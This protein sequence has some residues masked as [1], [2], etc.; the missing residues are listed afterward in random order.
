MWQAS[1]KDYYMGADQLVQSILYFTLLYHRLYTVSLVFAAFETAYY[2]P[3]SIGGPMAGI[4]GA[5]TLL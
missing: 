5:L 2:G 3:M 1:G 4:V